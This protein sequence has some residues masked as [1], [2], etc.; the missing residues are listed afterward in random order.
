MGGAA[1]IHRKF[2]YREH[3]PLTDDERRGSNGAGNGAAANGG[4]DLL[5][6]PS[7]EEY[8]WAP[9][10]AGLCSFTDIALSRLDLADVA[11]M[12]DLLAIQR[13]NDQRLQEARER[14]AERRANARVPPGFP[15]FKR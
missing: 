11:L 5:H 10:V 12:N 8:L 7:G 9:A 3:L 1:G 13:I 15:P 4:V 2:F 14:D 6:L